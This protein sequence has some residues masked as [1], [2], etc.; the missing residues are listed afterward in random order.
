MKFVCSAIKKFVLNFL[1]LKFVDYY[2]QRES[3]NI[4]CFLRSRQVSLSLETK[5]LC[6]SENY[7]HFC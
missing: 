7:L 2:L 3:K 5:F 1:M 4:K 6:L